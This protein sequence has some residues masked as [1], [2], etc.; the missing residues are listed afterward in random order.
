MNL[1]ETVLDF[2]FPP[3][4]GFCGK[5]GEGNLC[6]KCRKNIIHSN[7][8]FNQ[9]D[10]YQGKDTFID[11]HFYLFSYSELIRE[12]ILQYKFD[13]RAYLANTIYEFF[14]NN[15]KLYGFLK[16]YDIMIPIP[17]SS[18]RKRERGY[19]QSEI[20]ARKIS[21][22]AGIPIETQVLK[23]QKNNQPQ[24]SLNKQQ[25]RENVKNVYKVQNE[26]KIQD[27]KI[28]LFDDIYTTG[29]T[30]NECARILK[31]AN[32]QMVGILTIAKD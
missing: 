17:I 18:S 11:E 2:I 6:A 3:V 7:G 20:L 26:L 21:K 31:I 28:L 9:L 16:K 10:F 27:K 5:M 14:M 4:C 29:S 13:D 19:N 22:M 30:A 32:C 24:S 23:K 8:Y 1:L 15:E 12:K 25:R